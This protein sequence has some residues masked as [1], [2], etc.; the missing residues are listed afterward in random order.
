MTQRLIIETVE[1]MI[2]LLLTKECEFV[3]AYWRKTIWEIPKHAFYEVYAE[4]APIF[5]N[6]LTLFL[7]MAT[8]EKAFRDYA[9]VGEILDAVDM[10]EQVGP[11]EDKILEQDQVSYD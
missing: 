11:S 9:S 3:K 4:H 8:S 1:G 6:L 10:H 7:P 2:M 5:L